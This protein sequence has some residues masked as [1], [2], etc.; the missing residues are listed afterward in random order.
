MPRL[1]DAAIR[2]LDPPRKGRRLVFD[3]HKQA[4]KGF[5]VRVTAAGKRAF[6][7][8]Y[9]TPEGKDRLLTIGDHPTWSVAAA[10]KRAADLR[11][12]VDGGTDLLEQRRQEKAEPT[13]ADTAERFLRTKRDRKSYRDIAAALRNHL[14]PAIGKKK[15]RDVRR[16]DVIA[17]LE[18]LAEDRPRQAGIVLTYAKQ[19]F[20][21]AEDREIIEV[22]PIA[23]L[24]ATKLGKGLT[25][26]KRGR[27]LT[28]DEIR[29]L[30]ATTTPPQGMHR[31]TL[32]ALKTILVTGQR[33]GEVAGMRTSELH[34]RLWTIPADRRGKTESAH[35]VPLT[36]TAR[37]LIDEARGHRDYVFC[38]R[39]LPLGRAAVAKAVLRCTDALGNTV[40]PIWG[41]WTPHDLR[42]TMRTGLAAAGVSETVAEATVGHT[43]KG[44]AAVYDLHRYDAEKRAALEAWERRLLRIIE[45]KPSEDN[46]VSIQEAR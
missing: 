35:T 18:P 36:D 23:S 30:W 12:E 19:L 15:V 29:A 28:E 37:A 38:A 27:V 22:S 43:R 45:G 16:R 20:G 32:L 42:R 6:V 11:R 33:P 9:L 1:T 40:D 31:A 41:H 24:N 26:R 14:L 46:V 4:P 34:G 7:L 25:S 21:Y 3:D 13:V 17:L 39:G 5:G 10:R 44:I 2:K 8:R